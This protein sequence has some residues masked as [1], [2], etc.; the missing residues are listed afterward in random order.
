M[1]RM[2]KEKLLKMDGTPLFPE[3]IAH[4]LPYK[5]SPQEAALYKAVTRYVREEFNRA[6]VQ[7]SGKRRTVGFALTILQRRLASSPAAIL[8]SLQRRCE[9]LEERLQEIESGAHAPSPFSGTL[10][11]GETWYEA[12]EDAPDD[13]VKQLEED[14]LGQG[15]AALTV[16]ELQAEIATLKEL[17]KSAAQ[18]V[19][20]GE[21]M[22]W[23]AL[24]GLRQEIRIG[25]TPQ[26]SDG[27]ASRDAG[28]FEAALPGQKIIVFTEHLDTLHYLRGRIAT[29]F[30]REGAI[31]VIHGSK[32]REERLEA[33]EAFHSHAA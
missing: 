19:R 15:T 1:R 10:L 29:L 11:S 13:E 2:V 33:Q 25:R 8:R 16:E 20:S 30:G 24:S 3:R 12:M 5:L 9:K 4:T 21:D 32:K 14:I 22:K 17:E 31:T 28:K 7:A 6:E 23:Q 26:R 27:N 18:V